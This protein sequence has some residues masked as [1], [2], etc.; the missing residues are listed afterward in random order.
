MEE[1]FDGRYLSEEP[2]KEIGVG[3]AEDASSFA[4]SIR[5]DVLEG[6][7][8]L[9]ICTDALKSESMLFN[10]LQENSSG[11]SCVDVSYDDLS[12]MLTIIMKLDSDKDDVKVSVNNK[13]ISASEE[14]ACLIVTDFFGEYS[15][16]FY[17]IGRDQTEYILGYFDYILK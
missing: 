5:K 7:R 4:Y 6:G 12:G 8:Y 13:L 15:I 3:T 2:V 1:L 17:A 14:G 16:R 10:Q 9:Q 11:L